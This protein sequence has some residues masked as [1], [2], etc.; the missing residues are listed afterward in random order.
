M[1]KK[2]KVLGIIFGY[3]SFLVV[4]VLILS[5]FHPAI[6]YIVIGSVTVVSA[7]TLYYVVQQPATL[8]KMKIKSKTLPETAEIQLR[9]QENVSISKQQCEIL[10]DYLEA[11]PYVQDYANSE[12]VSD[13]FPLMNDVIFSSLSQAELAKIDQLNLSQIEKLEFIRDFLYFNIEER[14]TLIDNMLKSQDDVSNK[15]KYIPPVD[16]IS[17]GDKFRIHVISLIDPGE[18]KKIVIIDSFDTIKK[19]KK[20]IGILFNYDLDDFLLSSGGIILQEDLSIIDYPLEDDD[21]IVIIPS[22]IP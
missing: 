5:I 15:I 21:E 9:V 11:L 1:E 13:N 8:N 18:M 12:E 7:S 14:K 17:L 6:N 10:E 4:D 19:I 20:D 3:V 16:I 2:F 22:R